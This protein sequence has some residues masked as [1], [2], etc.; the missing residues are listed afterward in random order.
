MHLG[1]EDAFPRDMVTPSQARAGA[2]AAVS[3]L[4]LAGCT[5]ATTLG[6][7]PTD[8]L[9]AVIASI[10]SSTTTTSS[11]GRIPSPSGSRRRIPESPPPSTA[12]SR[13]LH[14]ADAYV[15]VPYVWGGNTPKGF[16][17]SGFT[18]YVFAKYGITL[19][20]TA[21]EQVRAGGAVPADFRALRPGD[22][23]MF[24]EPGEAISHVAIYVG[25]GRIIHSSGSTGGVG[26]TDLNSGG[27]WFVAYFVAARRVL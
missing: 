6:V 16:D 3:V 14:T 17:C 4:S 2:I 8:I 22:L 24:A 9:S 23:M 11:G 19:P 1:F 12:A 21:R 13:V 10:P 20:R 26:Y 15:G 27:D 18:K 5:S 7:S 25:N